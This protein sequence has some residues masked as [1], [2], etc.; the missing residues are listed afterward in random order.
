MMEPPI[1]V[2]AEEARR[3]SSTA[4]AS[5][6]PVVMVAPPMAAPA[7]RGFLMVALM[8]VLCVS[9]GSG[10]VYAYIKKIGPFSV[11]Q[12]SE[13][14]FLSSILAKSSE[15][16]TASYTFAS[17]LKMVQRDADAAP[18][19]VDTPSDEQL[20]QY[21]HDVRRISDLQS[22][23][24]TLSYGYGEQSIY[25]YKAKKYV[26]KPGKPYPSNLDVI[27]QTSYRVNSLKDPITA[28]PYTYTIT[29]G[30]K[31]FAISTTL[32]TQAAINALRTSSQFVA[33]TTIIEGKK[34]TF[35]KGSEYMYIPTSIPEPFLV[36][37]SDSLRSIPPDVS[38][39]VSVGAMTDLTKQGL[40]D[41]R[42][43]VKAVGGI[44]DLSYK[45]DVEARKKDENYYVRINNIPSIIPYLGSYKGMWI[46]ISPKAASSTKRDLYTYDYNPFSDI[47]KTISDTEKNYKTERTELMSELKSL[48]ELADEVKLVSFKESPTRENVDGRD[49]YQYKLAINKDAIV[50]FYSKILEDPSKYKKL[51]IAK[52]GGL[53]EYLKS[54]EFEKT[55]NYVNS[56]TQLTLWTDMNGFPARIEYRIRIVPPDS[57]V[58]LKE[59]QAEVVLSLDLADI[60]EPV[61]IEKPTGAKSI[62][63]V[64]NEIDA[65]TGSALSSA[66]KKANEAQIKSQLSIVRVGGELY[67]DG[68]GKS[69]YGSQ[70]WVVGAAKRCTEGMFKEGT[71]AKALVDADMVNAEAGGVAC[72]ANGKNYLVGAALTTKEWWCV[73]STGTSRVEFGALPTS[74]PASGKCP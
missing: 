42:F 32:E 20:A 44:G 10:V 45:V 48:V 11:S 31:N 30:G 39:S 34:V 72:Y 64:I 51:N 2:T 56:N 40:P 28:Q 46:E 29:E 57:A 47:A 27:A 8:L 74:L 5:P 12:Y 22:L 4:P 25:D 53:L 9:L 60:N 63:E 36:S 38:G 3:L 67:F 68:A 17:S 49:L 73:D 58:Q 1:V 19:T 65:N 35:T 43:N 6:V 21:D 18:F 37:L 23:V 70:P 50:T 24:S 14:N 41:W 66:R 55:F 7:R 59:K 62:Q 61:N 54:G 15:I 33:T 13:A 26:I 52:D 71:V 69:S 16:T